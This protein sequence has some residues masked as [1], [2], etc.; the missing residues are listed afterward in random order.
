SPLNGNSDSQ[1]H[2]RTSQ[3]VLRALDTPEHG[4]SSE[5][6][7]ARLREYGR[8]ELPA[9][10][11][12][13]GPM[14]FAAQFHNALIYFLL[15]A[16]VLAAVLGHAVDAGVIL[17]V[18]IINA[19]VGFVQEGRA[20]QSLS[21]LRAMLAPSARVLRDGQRCVMAVQDLVP[22]DLVLLEAGDRVPADL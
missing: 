19:I 22:G 10:R 6:A 5:S 3:D 8:N 18:V 17:L 7:A 4:L 2:A 9:A 15:A 11:Q 1:W 21:A 12:R 14:R 16:A 20:E 13:S